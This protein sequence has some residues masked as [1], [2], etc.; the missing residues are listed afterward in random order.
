MAEAGFADGLQVRVLVRRI[1]LFEP[2]GVFLKDQWSKIG[3]DV[4]LDVQE[5]AAFFEA[6]ANRDFQALV[7]GGSANTADPDDVGPWYL[8]GSSQNLSGL[9]N[10]EADAL[11][12]EMSS[13]T[14]PLR[15][16]ELADQWQLAV[17]GDHGTFVMYW[18][19]RFMGLRREVH[20]MILH[21]NIDNNLKMQDVWLSA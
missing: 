10:E 1:A 12:A 20:G 17:A 13:E 15:R 11:F 6:Q 19:E 16:K 14:D 3:I 2:V 21:P 5:N 7:A 18:R 4:V 8:C 9:C